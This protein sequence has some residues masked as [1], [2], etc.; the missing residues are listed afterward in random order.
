MRHTTAT[1]HVHPACTSNRHLIERLQAETG[2]LVVI[3]GGKAR[4]TRTAPR[5][6][7]SNP[8]GGDAA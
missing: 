8:W 1:L 2:H 5:T 7:P 6:L 4:L 3:H